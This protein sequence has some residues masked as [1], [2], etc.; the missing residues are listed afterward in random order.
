MPLSVPQT[1][2][3]NV[4]S[5]VMLAGIRNLG[6]CPC[7]RCLIPLDRAHN[8]GMPRDRQQRKALAQVDDDSRRAR[9]EAA[10]RIIYENNGA[11]SHKGVENLLFEESL[12]PTTVSLAP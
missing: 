1:S 12:V 9:V 2:S 3:D 10:R 4:H 6:R 5:R 11:V 8:L 7:P